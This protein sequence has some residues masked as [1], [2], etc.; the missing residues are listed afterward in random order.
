MDFSAIVAKVV[1]QGNRRIKQSIH[2]HLS[3][4]V[5]RVNIAMR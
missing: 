4:M 1:R 3:T 2:S 5:T